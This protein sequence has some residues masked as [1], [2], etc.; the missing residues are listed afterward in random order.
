MA[1]GKDKL[2][3]DWQVC[4]LKDMSIGRA[5]RGTRSFCF[6]VICFSV[7][8]DFWHVR[9]FTSFFCTYR[10]P[11][12]QTREKLIWFTYTEGVKIV[13]IIFLFRKNGIIILPLGKK[14]F[15]FWQGSGRYIHTY[16]FFTKVM[17]SIHRHLFSLIQI[18]IHDFCSCITRR[19]ALLKYACVVNCKTLKKELLFNVHTSQNISF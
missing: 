5:K 2:M 1:K 4:V 17:S 15:V 8:L 12:N 19:V 3:K 11:T 18:F 13:T 7:L 10:L 6:H 16:M 9:F 14:L